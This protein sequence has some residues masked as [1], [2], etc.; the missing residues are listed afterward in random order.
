MH[1]QLQSI[2]QKA[3]QAFQDGNF[4]RAD[5]I[6]KR[7]LLV[8]AK[9]L[10]AIQVLSLIKVSHPNY[11]EAATL[12]GGVAWILLMNMFRVTGNKLFPPSLFF[13]IIQ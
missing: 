5:S 6:L 2:L 7:A 10:P 9:N 13:V 11:V 3:I 12:L 1:A 8:D 4:D